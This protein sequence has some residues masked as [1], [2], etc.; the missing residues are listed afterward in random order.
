[1]SGT[2]RGNQRL[3]TLDRWIGCPLVW[4]LGL[5]RTK[6]T[7]PPAITHIGV[8]MFGA[9]G[10]A[11]L[12]ASIIAD[13]RSAYPNT[14]VTAFASDSNRG[15]LDLLDGIDAVVV[16]P[17]K[18][19]NLAIR[20]IRET[21]V[22]VVLDTGQWPRISAIL[23]CL[24]G[25]KF[26]IGF[27]TP[28][29]FRHWAFDIAVEHSRDCHEIVNFRRLLGGLGITG[30]SFPKFKS[31][32]RAGATP[33]RSDRYVVFH[34]WATGFRSN[35]REWD[36]TNWVAL[37]KQIFDKQLKIA[38][39][40]SQADVARAQALACAINEPGKVEILAGAT[41]LKGTAT[42][43]WLAEAVVSVN[44][45]IMHLAA[46]LGCPT[47]G[48]HGPTNPLRWGPVGPN[49]NVV[50]PNPAGGCGYLNLG[51]EYPRNP[52]NCMSRLKVADVMDRL[53]AVIEHDS[54]RS[55]LSPN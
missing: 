14:R 47:V 4:T 13:I 6:R 26:T 2:D 36:E 42:A 1:M 22:D 35:L 20:A 52:P 9:I 39:T 3:R 44:T 10:D 7:K 21:R 54:R 19:P 29:Q 31:E 51:Y 17:I 30:T 53:V 5:V 38:I 18:H 50:A 48:L 16:V 23:A 12:A 37:A 40:G 45:G 43:L 33:L 8:L 28:G 25:A 32:L 41:T 15:T 55:L 34:P 11:L 49:T 24:S 27:K 46:L